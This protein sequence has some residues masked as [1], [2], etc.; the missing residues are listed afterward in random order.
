[1]PKFIDIHTM[2]GATKE[3]VAAAHEKDLA[4]QAK[5]GASFTHFWVDEAQ[6][7]VFCLSE[8]PNI[9]AAKAVHAEAGHPADEIFE[10]KEG[11]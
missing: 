2:P 10:V 9:E 5:H 6:G 7:K 4:V 11:S 3:A 1:M 8:A